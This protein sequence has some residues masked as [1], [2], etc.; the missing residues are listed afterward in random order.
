[1][2]LPEQALSV[3]DAILRMAD[4]PNQSIFTPGVPPCE[5]ETME[6]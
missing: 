1:M 2:I 3:R 5:A 6:G 4:D